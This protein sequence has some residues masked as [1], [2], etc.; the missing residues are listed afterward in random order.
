M[1]AKTGRRVNR[2]EKWNK[3][4]LYQHIPYNSK[5]GIQTEEIQEI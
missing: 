1:E 2:K 5:M 4:P 3:I